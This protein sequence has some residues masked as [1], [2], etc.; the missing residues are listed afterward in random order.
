[1]FLLATNKFLLNI[2]SNSPDEPKKDDEYITPAEKIVK[3][4][5]MDEE[6]DTISDYFQM[7]EQFA[8]LDVNSSLNPITNSATTSEKETY[9][10]DEAILELKNTIDKLKDKGVK[11]DINEMNFDKSYQMIIK[12][13]KE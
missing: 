6:E 12:I 8:S 7:P 3:G 10:V 9:T 2:G 4:E 5:D 1:M 13:D 11:I